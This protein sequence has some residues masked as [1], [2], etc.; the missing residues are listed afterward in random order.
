MIARL[1]PLIGRRLLILPVSLLVIVT[2]AFALVEVIP[3]DPALSVA[4]PF[5]TEEKVAEIRTELGLDRPPLER[6]GVYLGG[7]ATGNLGRSFYTK[8]AVTEEI[9]LFLPNTIELVVLALLVSATLGLALGTLGAWY[10]GRPADR[11]SRVGFSVF[12]S[13]PDFLLALLLVYLVFFLLG[14]AP[15]PVGRLDVGEARPESI[16]GFLLLD[17][18]LTG[19]LSTFWS[20]VSH[21]FLPVLALGVVYCAFLGKT[22]RATLGEALDSEYVEHARACGLPARQVLWYGLQTARAPIITYAA[23]LF[24]TLIGGAAI[25]E[26]IF[27][28]GGVGQWALEGILQKDI[29]VIQGFILLSGLVTLLAY[30]AL[31]ILVGLLDPRITYD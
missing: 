7:L 5:P 9:R 24:G 23:I 25:V 8:R 22:A 13:V 30:L 19:N 16:T 14:L 1:A 2:V 29:P 21:L 12:Q 17:S 26:Q 18:L 31:D 6:Y 27:G 28:W 4:G 10:R 11:A 3:G 15:A 20:A